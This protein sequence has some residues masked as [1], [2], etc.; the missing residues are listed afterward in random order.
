MKRRGG[1]GPRLEGHV[2]ARDSDWRAER[3]GGRNGAR[4]WWRARRDPAAPFAVKVV[5]E[6]RIVEAKPEAARPGPL[7]SRAFSE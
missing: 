1:P 7:F 4:T 3:T 6:N 5:T 2:C